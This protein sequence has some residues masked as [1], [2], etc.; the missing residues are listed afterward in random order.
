[1]L[2]A[3]YAA[4]TLLCLCIVIAGGLVASWLSHRHKER[5]RAIFMRRYIEEQKRKGGSRDG[6]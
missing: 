4:V 3:R 1:M 2:D 6:A 5:Q